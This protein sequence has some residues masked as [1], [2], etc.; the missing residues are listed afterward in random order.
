M[1]DKDPSNTDTP[2]LPTDAPIDPPGAMTRGLEKPGRPNWVHGALAGMFLYLFLCAINV[3][4]AGLKT[5]GHNSS[6]LEDIFKAAD[7]P[8]V[9]LMGSVLVTS[10]V[11][12]SSFTTSLIIAL[13]G[14]GVMDVQTAV[15]A[16]MGANIGTSVTSVIVSLGNVRI[17]RQFR[18]AFTSALIHDIFNWLTV[19]ILFPMEWISSAMS[20]NGQGWLIRASEFLAHRM[21]G[22]ASMDK[23]FNPIKWI[24]SPVKHAFEWGGHQIADDPIVRGALIAAVGLVLLF[25]SLFFLV[26]NLKGAFLKRLEGLFRSFFF[27]NDL[28]AYIVGAIT[29]VIVQSSSV[30]TS[31]IVPLAGA[32]AVRISRVFPFMLG[33]NLG[34]TVTGV[35]AATAN[36]VPDAVAVAIAHVTFNLIGTAIWYPLKTVPISLAYG[37]GRIASRSK[38]YA[39]LF[40]LLVFFVIPMVGLLLTELFG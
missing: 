23:P 38:R 11:Q 34:T 28:I 31:L 3:M 40:L 17:R 32:G 39:F 9:A 20:A 13:T 8:F 5:I 12:S 15:Y 6:I 27:R 24:T 35:I 30:T 18:R 2:D 7:N 19:A 10:I 25:V 21:V 4:G 36:P 22:E 1:T 33:A 26:Q 37:F 16:V 29:T 14:A